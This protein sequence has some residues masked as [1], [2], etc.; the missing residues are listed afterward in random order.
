MKKAIPHIFMC[1]LLLAATMISLSF[2]EKRNDNTHV[3][4]SASWANSYNSINDLAQSSDIIAVVEVLER[5]NSYY[6]NP[7]LPITEFNV[8]VCMPINGVEENDTFTVMQTGICSETKTVEIEDDPLLEIG[9]KYLIFGY[10]NDMNSVTILGGPQG[11]FVYDNGKV[12]SLYLSNQMPQLKANQTK[13]AGMT[14]EILLN[15]VAIEDV[16]TKITD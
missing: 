2:I 5:T 12:T 15:N 13:V 4:A 8:K 6:Y 1:S 14:D 16:I 10:K 9:E 3:Y 11:R 7:G